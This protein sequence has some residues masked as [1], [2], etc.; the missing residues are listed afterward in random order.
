M[1][2]RLIYEDGYW[3]IV[4]EDEKMGKV[5]LSPWPGGYLWVAGKGVE[6]R[7]RSIEEASQFVGGFS[8]DVSHLVIGLTE[9]K[10][11]ERCHVNSV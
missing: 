3:K 4:A 6:L 5:Y 2:P 10:E 1:K 11:N 7:C 9:I 8:V